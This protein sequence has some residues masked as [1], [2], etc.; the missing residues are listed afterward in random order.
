MNAHSF[1]DFEIFFI[2]LDGTNSPIIDYLVELSSK[3]KELFTEAIANI[4]ELPLSH[5]T[6]NNIKPFKH[7]K[8]SCYELRIKCGN[9]ICRFFYKIEHPNFLVIHGF[10]KKTPKTSKK[11]IS[12]GESNLYIY[13]QTKLKIKFPYV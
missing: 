1:E 13:N 9:D 2:S 7:G 3:N 5:K 10:T 11:D 12:K 8:F 6:L 4:Q